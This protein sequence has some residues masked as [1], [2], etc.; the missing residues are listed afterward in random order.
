MPGSGKSCVALAM[1]KQYLDIK[2]NRSPTEEYPDLPV[3]YVTYSTKLVKTIENIWNKSPE[4]LDRPTLVEFK[5]YDELMGEE[6]INH[7]LPEFSHWFHSYLK[8]RPY[9]Q[10]EL[11]D[12]IDYK[13]SDY[14][15]T[16][17]VYLQFRMM[18]GYK[19][20]KIYI[21]S[22]S[23][24]DRLFKA[25]TPH[26]AGID[27]QAP[28]IYCTLY[29]I[30]NDYRHYLRAYNYI[31]TALL[32]LVAKTQYS[33]IF[34]DEAQS[35]SS[36]QLKQLTNLAHK[37]QIAY[38]IDNNQSLHENFS[39]L[40]YLKYL[41]H[42]Q[43]QLIELPYA[44][45]S[46]KAIQELANKV[47][48]LK[49]YFAG[50]S[51]K[52][53]ATAMKLYG[54]A[55]EGLVSWV[56]QLGDDAQ[57]Y[58][59]QAIN[60]AII[61]HPI[62]LNQVRADYP[63][64]IILT[65]E[66][67]VGLE[68][69]HVILYHLLERIVDKE[70]NQLAQGFIP[71]TKTPGRAKNGAAYHHYGALFN[72]LFTAI[73]RARLTVTIVYSEKNHAFSQVLNALKPTISTTAHTKTILNQP[74]PERNHQEEL[75]EIKRLLV[76]G[77]LAA[78]KHVYQHRFNNQNLSFETW[79]QQ[80]TSNNEERSKE[81]TIQQQ[82]SLPKNIVELK[83]IL[84]GKE[85]TSLLFKYT[86]EKPC[87]FFIE[88]LDEE[89]RH[90]LIELSQQHPILFDSLIQQA[91]DFAQQQ[92]HILLQ[93]VVGSLEQ[94]FKITNHKIRQALKK[95]QA[96]IKRNIAQLADRQ[97][98][99]P[100]ATLDLL[101]QCNVLNQNNLIAQSTNTQ[102]QLGPTI[103]HHLLSVFDQDL[104]DNNPN[105]LNALI[106]HM[107]IRSNNHGF[108]NDEDLFDCLL[109]TQKG[110]FYIVKNFMRLAPTIKPEKL[111]KDIGSANKFN[112]FS[113]LYSESTANYLLN[114]ERFI[115]LASNHLKLFTEK[116]FSPLLDYQTSTVQEEPFISL[117]ESNEGI[118]F[119]RH[120][121][122]LP[123][124]A[125]K[126]VKNPGLLFSPI[127]NELNGVD[128]FKGITPFLILSRRQNG[129]LLLREKSVWPSVL[130]GLDNNPS[131]LF[132]KISLTIGHTDINPFFQ[133]AHSSEMNE[134]L[135]EPQI[136]SLLKKEKNLST[137]FKPIR[138]SQG[139]NFTSFYLLCHKASI[140]QL[141]KDSMLW[142]M[143]KK[144][145]CR[146]SSPLFW[147]I[148]SAN[149]HN[150]CTP[151]LWLCTSEEGL[152]VLSDPDILA[153]LEKN[154]D[155]LFVPI[156]TAGIL[157]D[158]TAFHLLCGKTK[159]ISFLNDSGLW[160]KILTHFNNQPKQT[161]N[162]LTHLFTKVRA[163]GADQS[164]TAFFA[165][166]K[167]PK[168]IPMLEQASILDLLKNDINQ[169]F[170]A[171]TAAGHHT[172]L[173]PLYLL[174][175]SPEG[176]AFVRNHLWDQLITELQK[177]PSL[178]FIPITG[179][180][181]YQG[182]TIFY[183]LCSTD[184]GLNMLKDNRLWPF[185]TKAIEN[186][187]S[188]LFMPIR[189]ATT[190]K[191]AYPFLELCSVAKG[192]ELLTELWP[193]YEKLLKERP[194]LF[195]GRTINHLAYEK[196]APVQL[197][198]ATKHGLH[199]IHQKLATFKTI[200]PEKEFNQLLELIKTCPKQQR[201]TFF[202]RTI[203]DNDDSKHIHNKP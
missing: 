182:S 51:D 1:L 30:L 64:V 126:L 32:P 180:G 50:L 33:H 132:L 20:A 38:F 49:Y 102:G 97:H 73:T 142:A 123:L 53:A 56:H 166:C 21:A 144:Q 105:I 25:S 173:T 10:Q 113:W 178:I 181:S 71:Y 2:T 195:F 127:W 4:N 193:T 17:L 23:Q 46:A 29:D 28:K 137:I 12:N 70:A 169:L 129:I 7:G 18:S 188:L 138:C 96:N 133:I 5:T 84:A 83:A 86:I 59:Q 125:I 135:K 192:I 16:T 69:D 143:V 72:Q 151:L 176:L 76:T 41:L 108:F 95:M 31:D 26:G 155:Q 15:L 111:F 149:F 106:N 27:D 87:S 78:A 130:Q 177:N 122:I 170:S 34:V 121:R 119:L 202:Q 168:S 77:N 159:G 9:L 65:P 199:F 68:Y 163:E 42:N 194:S 35:F 185:I 200:L 93:L 187:P 198:S 139:E 153:F 175:H 22:S 150:E 54:Q 57:R 128:D 107:D 62:D 24:R 11:I 66:E 19:T 115:E 94:W 100:L 112:F 196:L 157:Q 152:D 82:M 52:G 117:C 90:L 203:T 134:I 171:I 116:L 141:Q 184:N 80:I 61:C 40:P 154:I 174:C 37:K 103:L 147:Q 120:K 140:G 165:L 190:K 114:N 167:Y 74:A 118:Q 162:L 101:H 39:K 43:Y 99:L 131:L 98:Q 60:S 136:L 36:L 172:G 189:G 148:S 13:E 63:G 109:K 201:P 6:Q 8:T 158:R 45:R 67:A 183:L 81:Q 104:I 85:T 58:L 164:S 75:D 160:L 191:G 124:L 186:N 79:C 197:L 47:L 146:A 3:L 44:I 89:N 88:L 92:N 55:E 156:S 145:I 91:C 110:R 14:P 48:E 179:S 161:N